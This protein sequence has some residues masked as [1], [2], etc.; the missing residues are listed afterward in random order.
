MGKQIAHGTDD[1]DRDVTVE[2][3]E[4]DLFVQGVT[5]GFAGQDSYSIK[6]DGQTVDT[7]DTREDAMK[8]FG[9]SVS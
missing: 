4:G 3:N 9:D 6:R 7:A 8:K 2:K 5:L 1:K